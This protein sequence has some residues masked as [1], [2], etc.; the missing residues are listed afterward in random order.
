MPRRSRQGSESGVYHF[1]NRGIN[2]NRLFHGPR[3]YERYLELMDEHRRDLGIK[4]YH[5]CL[6]SNHTHILLRSPDLH[7]LSRFGHYLQ[8]RYAYYH[9]RAHPGPKQVFTKRFLSIPVEKDSYLLECG[10]YIERNPVRARLVE[11]PRNF[12]YSS[13]AFYALG[14]GER[15]ITPNPLYEDMGWTHQERRA[16]YKAYVSQARPYEAMVDQAITNSL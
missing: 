14:R 6:M 7:S 8:R 5:Y 13:Y 9:H 1:I 4:I 11:D 16:R 10:R 2:K 3:D 12:D 15:I